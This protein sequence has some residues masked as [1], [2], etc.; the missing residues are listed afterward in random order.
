M[1]CIVCMS[2]KPWDLPFLAVPQEVAALRRVLRL[3]L[4]VWRLPE[5]TDV[6][7]LCVS[8]LVSNVI[9]HVGLETPTTLAVSMS[10][11]Y[12]RIEVHDPDSRALPTLVQAGLGSESGR[13]VVLVDAVADRWGVELRAD[14]KVTW[15][16]LDTGLPSVCVHTVRPLTTGVDELLNGYRAKKVPN[17]IGAGSDPLTLAAA[18]EAA[19]DI[20]ADLLRWM[21][22]HGRNAD[23]VLDRAQTHFEAE[24]ER[25][26]R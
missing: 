23:D 12:L 20:I 18:E 26:N 6:A 17:V 14:R 1:N 2:R 19:I 5:V 3:H 13:G 15:C 22:A 9:N 21:Q 24:A 16:E 8:E 4:E 25:F 11:S 7:Q 10:G